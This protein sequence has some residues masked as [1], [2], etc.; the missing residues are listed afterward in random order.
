MVSLSRFAHAYNLGEAVALIHSLR[1]KP[2]YLTND[3]YQSLKV[4]LDSSVRVSI[5]NIPQ[6]IQEEFRELIKCKVLV[7]SDDEDEQVLHFIRSRIPKPSISVCYFILS[8]QCNLAC[9]YCFLGNNSADTRK[10]FSRENMSVKT[11]DKAIDFYVRQLNLSEYNEIRKPTVIF[12][13]G[14]P[15]INFDVLEHIATRLNSLRKT[16]NHLENL[17]MS[18]ITNGLL[19]NEERLLKLKQLGIQI[20]ISVDGFTEEANNMRVDVLGKPVFTRLLKVLD[21][22]KRLDVNVSLSV[23]LSEETIKSTEHI[24]ELIKQYD[25]KGLGFNIMMSDETFILP[26]SYNEK[27]ASFIIDAFIKFRELGIYEDRIMRKLDAFAK[28]Q[29]Y[30]SDCAATSGG[31]IVIVPDGRVGVCHGCVA[32][33]KYFIS[34]VDDN[35]FD[36]RTNATFLEWSQLSPVNNEECLDCVALGICGGGCPVNAMHSK[37]NGTLHSIDERFCVH[38]KKTLEFLIKDLYN[39]ILSAGVKSEQ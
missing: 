3:I 7:Q 29:V 35:K 38:S 21:E 36:A 15:L 8:E 32:G 20:A 9:K 24:F 33:K 27:A 6:N 18:V 5:E 30:F 2:V 39:N 34:D 12:Y 11:A 25:I 31:Q 19:L 26:Q 37:P 17:E 13:G 28:S 4:Y 22:C 14:E 10:N 1:M 16:E 23:T